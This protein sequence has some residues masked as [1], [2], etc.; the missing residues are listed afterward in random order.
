M[1]VEKNDYVT[2]GRAVRKIEG[3]PLDMRIPPAARLNDIVIVELEGLLLVPGDML[4]AIRWHGGVQ[5]LEIAESLAIL[6]VLE[7]GDETARTIVRSL[8][9]D[10]A[11]GDYVIPAEVYRVPATLQQAVDREG[12]HVELLAAEVRQALLSEGD[13]VFIDA[14]AEDGV[15]I[16]DEFVFFDPRDASDAP[17]EDR[18]ATVRIV[19][20]ESGTATGRITH[21]RDTSPVEGSPGRRILRAVG[22]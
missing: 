3:N 18:L 19:R 2:Y 8:Y 7:A 11:I 21:L 13:M 15:A 12:M 1:L 6:E 16:G 9:G 22:S 20:V 5:G 14:G 17:Y 4:R 10:F